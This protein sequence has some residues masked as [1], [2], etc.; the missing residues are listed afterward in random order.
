MLKLVLRGIGAAKGR[1]ALTMLSI[2]FGVAFVSGSFILADSLRSVFNQVS[3]DIFAGVDAVVR[4][5]EGE[6]SNSENPLRFDESIATELAAVDG[7]A[8]IEPGL[9]AFETFYTV[10]A[11]GE[12]IRLQ[13]PP[14]LSFSWAGPSD[15]SSFDLI[16]GTPPSG[17]QIAI[18]VEQAELGDFEI[19]DMVPVT[20]PNDGILEFELSALVEFGSPGVLFILFDLP[21]IQN[22]LGEPGLIDGIVLG[23]DDGVAADE[24]VSRLQTVAP[25]DIEIVSGKTAEQETQAEFGEFISIFGNILLGFALVTL[26]VSIFIIYNTFAILVSQRTKQM[27]LLRAIGASASQVRTMV[28]AESVVVGLIASIGGLFAGIGV[29]SALKWLF[30]Q[31]GGAFPEG[32]LEIQLRTI[33]VVMIVGMFVTVVS[34]ILPAIRASR[35]SPL[36]ALQDTG[37]QQRSMRFRIIAG[38]F[39]LIPGVILLGLGL[40]GTSGTTTGVLSLLGFGSVLTFIGVAM[41]SALFAGKASSLIGN[42]VQTLKGTTGRLARDNASR[43]PQ[44]TAATATALMIGLALITGVTVL[45]TSIKATFSGLL[46]DSLTAD[47]F[48]F[49]ENQGLPFSPELVTELDGLEATGPVSGFVELE[50]TYDGNEVGISSFDTDVGDQIIA[51]DLVEGTSNVGSD[52]VAILDETADDLGLVVGDTVSLDFEGGSTGP[53]TVAGIFESNPLLEGDWIVDRSVTG[54]LVNID[55]IDFIGLKY[56]EGVD[57]A[58]GRVAV[59]EVA[60]GFPQLT[61]QDNAEFQQGIEDQINQLLV[62]I[63]G[64][65]GLCLVIA[66]FGI[67]N[68]MA[69]SVLERTREIGLLRAVGM[70]RA[71][72]RSSIRWEAIIVSV[73]GAL[74]GVLMGVVLAYAGISAL[75]EDFITSVAVPYANLVLYVVLGGLLGVLAAYFPARRAAKLNVLDAIA[76]T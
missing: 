52:G 31:G 70:T 2:I 33:V 26:F 66:F 60:A 64:L 58:D 63:N 59:D 43:N 47:I 16:E 36:E 1:L 72:L 51:I 15:V 37:Q 39:V 6:V 69:L 71:Q 29:A 75:P 4:V 21:T 57:A 7:V 22:L 10:D 5:P 42:P 62:V 12:V 32:P 3:E 9:S 40:A 35:I 50:A 38:A 68:T 44:R 41:L 14:V 61:V 48:V 13:G 46:E 20:T 73:F 67:I 24:L 56:V 49:E 18:D 34:A 8:A 45:A 25:A 53:L 27:G 55:A 65:L 74:L 30:S 76:T 54:P 11:E 28:L 23:A 19:G 17:N